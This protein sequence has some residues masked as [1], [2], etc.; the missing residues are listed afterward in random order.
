MSKLKEADVIEIR[1]RHAD[2]VK[3]KDLAAAYPRVSKP[4]LH[5]IIN[6]RRWR[7]LLGKE[8]ANG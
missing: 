2:G 7:Y 4:N 6:G 1:R 3:L 5:H 8:A